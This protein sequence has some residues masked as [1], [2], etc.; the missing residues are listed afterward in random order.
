[1][2]LEM[3]LTPFDSHLKGYLTLKDI[4]AMNYWIPINKKDIDKFNIILPPN[5]TVSDKKTAYTPLLKDT[6]QTFGVSH[7][8][9]GLGKLKIFDNKSQKEFGIPIT[10]I[11][12][13][14]LKDWKIDK[15]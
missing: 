5:I 15:K 2:Q 7:H 9:T 8:S 4:F 3:V 10:D 1:M 6:N 12:N 14:P 13:K 11:L